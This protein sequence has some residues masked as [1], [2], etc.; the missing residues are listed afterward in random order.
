MDQALGNV[1]RFIHERQHPALIRAG[2]VHAQFETI[3]PFLDGNGR[4]GRLLI[5]FMLCEQGVLS[6]PLL[7]LSHYLK[8]HRAEY[9]D[10]LQAVRTDGRWEEWL[11]F[12]LFGVRQVADQAVVKARQITALRES[13]RA[14]LLQQGQSSGNML[15]ALDL[16]FR[17]PILTISYL[18]EQLGMTFGGANNMANRLMQ[19]GIVK[20]VTGNRRNRRFVYDEYVQLFRDLDLSKGE[21]EL[22]GMD[23]TQLQ[24][25]VDTPSRSD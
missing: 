13:H 6:R 2:L 7:Y 21:T 1:E 10:R 25:P 8:L 18:S 24:L 11:L 5:T 19:L 16:L 3:H 12:F 22:T 9:Y 23:Q 14:L 17:Q 4:V 15:R 20:E